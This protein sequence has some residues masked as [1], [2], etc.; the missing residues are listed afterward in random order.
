MPVLSELNGRTAV[1]TGAASGIGAALASELNAQGMNLVIG[2]IDGD[3]VNA[4]AS[5]LRESGARCLPMQVD[6]SDPEAVQTFADAAFAEFGSVELLCNNAGV[7]LFGKVADASL[8][9][10]QWL[11]AVNVQGLLNSLHSFLPRMRA[12]DGWKHVVNTASTHAFLDNP[13][14]S[15]LYTASKQA[16]VGITTGLRYELASEG[17]L[18]TLL[19]PG[20]VST[21]ILDSQRNRPSDFGPR[22]AE[23]FGTGVI[24][25]GITPEEVAK[26]AVAGILAESPIVF[27]LEE[28]TREHFRSQVRNAWQEADHALATPI[29]VEV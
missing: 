5:R 15:A 17:V 19:C 10:W 11:S 9:D 16:I 6:M 25:F 22:A 4:L 28:S 26:I 2:D 21:R 27:A 29:G 8:G 18:V 24:P 20:Q 12:Q 3:G 13:Q 1:V 23:P 14:G 7:L